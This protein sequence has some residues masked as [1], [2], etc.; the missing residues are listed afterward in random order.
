MSERGSALPWQCFG[1]SPGGLWLKAERTAATVSL[2]WQV[3]TR[4]AR[5]R[6]QTIDANGK[7]M[8][9]VAVARERWDAG[10]VCAGEIP[11]DDALVAWAGVRECDACI[12]G[13]MRHL[14]GLGVAGYGESL[15]EVVEWFRDLA[16]GV[17]MVEGAS[18]RVER[19]Q[20]LDGLAGA[21]GV[22]RMDGD[23]DD[24]VLDV[25]VGERSFSIALDTPALRRALLQA[26]VVASED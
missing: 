26:A 8:D 6:I 23:G 21:V 7:V 19:H 3:R 12:H 10:W 24:P 18:Y 11:I 4:L 1:R 20:L 16:Q 17:W 2:W 25:R 5:G 22:L 15:G 14:V 9:D 13:I